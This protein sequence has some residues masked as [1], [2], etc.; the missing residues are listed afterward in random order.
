[1]LLY[2]IISP[3]LKKNLFEINKITIEMQEGVDDDNSDYAVPVLRFY[4]KDNTFVDCNL[5]ML[6]MVSIC[7]VV[8]LYKA[9][10]S[11]PDENS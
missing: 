7:F 6:F 5:I 8:M 11:N 2:G 10:N 4:Y 3:F 9:R 1:M